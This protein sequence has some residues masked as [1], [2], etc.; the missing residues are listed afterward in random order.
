MGVN[1]IAI[2]ERLNW[3]P[4]KE[5]AGRF[6]KWYDPTYTKFP[7]EANPQRQKAD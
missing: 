4:L 7:E 1:M 6:L 5:K 2:M 3:T